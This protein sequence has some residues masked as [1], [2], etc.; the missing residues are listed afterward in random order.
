[1]KISV[2]TTITNP[3]ERQD[4]WQEALSCFCDFADEVIVVNVGKSLTIIR[5]GL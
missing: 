3:E 1:M 4:R 2:I 5:C